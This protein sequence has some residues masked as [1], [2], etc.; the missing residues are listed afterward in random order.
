[1]VRHSFIVR[2]AILSAAACFCISCTRTPDA[3]LATLNWH[4][5]LDQPAQELEEN[6]AAEQQQQPMNYTSLNLGFLL[7]A[8]LYILFDQYLSSLPPDKRASAIDRQRRWLAQRASATTKAYAEYVGGTLA[9][10]AANESFI[11]ITKARIVEL[12]KLFNVPK[13]PSHNS[14]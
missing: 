3:T 13:N 11:E 5:T 9:S 4:P 2:R 6:L 10:F 1:M 8:K 7:D 14:N 12:Q